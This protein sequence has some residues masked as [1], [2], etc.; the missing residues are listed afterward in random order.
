MKKTVRVELNGIEL[1]YICQVIEG[2]I[3]EYQRAGEPT[4]YDKQFLERLQGIYKS[5]FGGK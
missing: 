1:F 2:A 5:N 4:D 3:L